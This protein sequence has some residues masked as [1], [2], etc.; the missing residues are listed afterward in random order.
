MVS[1]TVTESL[2]NSLLKLTVPGLL[3]G[4]AV[5]A[6]GLAITRSVA[7]PSAYSSRVTINAVPAVAK[8]TGTFLFS[9]KVFGYIA[10]DGVFADRRHAQPRLRLKCPG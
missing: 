5:L 9:V 1:I 3:V 4:A 10:V 2:K 7:D 8:A 6:A